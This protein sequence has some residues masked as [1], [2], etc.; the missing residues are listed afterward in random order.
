MKYICIN[1]TFITLP[2]TIIEF[3]KDEIYEFEAVPGHYNVFNQWIPFGYRYESHKNM[4]WDGKLS[5]D[6]VENNFYSIAEMRDE[7]INDLFED[8]GL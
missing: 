6:V 2:M 8:D 3:R 4:P 5:R 1:S 7:K